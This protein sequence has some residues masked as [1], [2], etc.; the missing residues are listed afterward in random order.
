MTRA[1]DDGTAGAPRTLLLRTGR[2][3]ARRRGSFSAEICALA[4]ESAA[5]GCVDV[6]VLEYEAFE[7]ALIGGRRRRGCRGGGSPGEPSSRCPP[8]PATADGTALV[9]CALQQ[10]VEATLL[11]LSAYGYRAR[12]V[13]PY[14]PNLA[15]SGLAGNRRPE[16]GYRQALRSGRAPT[17][18]DASEQ[19]A[20][21]GDDRLRAAA[22]CSE[23]ASQTSVGRR[24][25]WTTH[26]R[27][28]RGL[29]HARSRIAKRKPSLARG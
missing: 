7:F 11:S 1:P 14:G 24:S 4:E 20:C 13:T 22:I 16:S 10:R 5:R 19:R 15:F 18:R 9:A 2:S 3:V 23:R 27:L 28:G 26:E 25:P 29:D 17:S 6:L 8:H 12:I 21:A